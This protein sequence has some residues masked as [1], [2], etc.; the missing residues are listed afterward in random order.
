MTGLKFAEVVTKDGKRFRAG[1]GQYKEIEKT[2]KGFIVNTQDGGEWVIPKDSVS[3]YRL[4][5]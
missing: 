2:D 3:R 5:D 1:I 4:S